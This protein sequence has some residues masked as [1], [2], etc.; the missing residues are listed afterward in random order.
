MVARNLVR[1]IAGGCAAHSGHAKHLAHTLLK[2]AKGEAPDY[3]IKGARDWDSKPEHVRPAASF[4]L[5]Q[6][7]KQTLG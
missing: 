5:A 6:G 4:Q 3:T 2:A 1:A 7:R